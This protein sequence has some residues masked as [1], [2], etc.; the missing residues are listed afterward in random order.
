MCQVMPARVTKLDGN[1]A[2]IIDDGEERAI[3]LLGV[4]GITVGDYVF[5]H[6]GLVLQRI[7]PEEATAILAAFAELSALL[8]A[9]DTSEVDDVTCAVAQVQNEERP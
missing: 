2:W 4:D 6:A 7:E 3:S 8:L 5:H 1:I 9:M